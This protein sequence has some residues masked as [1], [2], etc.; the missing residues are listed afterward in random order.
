ML[1]MKP[2]FLTCT[3]PRAHQLLTMLSQLPI[4]NLQGPAVSSV[5]TFM[6][7]KAGEDEVGGLI[8]MA[9]YRLVSLQVLCQ[10]SLL[11]SDIA[12][13]WS[14]VSRKTTWLWLPFTTVKNTVLKFSNPQNNWKFCKCSSIGQL[15]IIRNSGELKTGLGQDAG[16][17]LGLKPLSKRYRSWFAEICSG[18]KI[19]SRELNIS[20]QSSHASSGTIYTWECTATQKDTTLLLLWKRSKRQEHSISCSGTPKTGTKTSSS[21]TR[22]SSLSRSNTATIT[23]RF[24]LERPLRCIPR[25]QGGH[26][27]SY[28]MVWYGVSHQGVTTLHFYKKGVKQC[29]SVSR[30][31]ARRSCDTSFNMTLFS[32]L[33]WVFQQDSAPA[34]NAKTTQIV[35]VEERCSL[36]QHQEL[37][38]G[39]CRPQPTRL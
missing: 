17:V 36:H 38:L 27:P 21:R 5:T 8:R 1:E 31:H 24:T 4:I 9:V 28:F 3:Q 6:L 10:G 7:S 15:N 20:Y 22:K 23:T 29:L 19:M 33:K 13:T 25:V 32:G 34:H 30:G 12:S 11:E 37:A 14:G 26:H 16:K 2:Q 39:E 35:A 18:N